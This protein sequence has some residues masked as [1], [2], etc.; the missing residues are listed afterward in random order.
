MLMVKI[1]WGEMEKQ[2]RKARDG[3]LKICNYHSLTHTFMMII[4]DY[5]VLIVHMIKGSVC[6][7][8]PRPSWAQVDLNMFS[9]ESAVRGE[10][11]D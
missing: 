10:R 2:D 3:N 8:G 4:F 7:T 1:K 5:M 11:Q 6:T 9:L